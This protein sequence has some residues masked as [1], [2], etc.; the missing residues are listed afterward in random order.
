MTVRVAAAAAASGQR[1]PRAGPAAAAAAAALRLSHIGPHR[2]RISTVPVRRRLARTAATG[3]RS[4]SRSRYDS[5]LKLPGAG[6]PPP[7]RPGR[8]GLLA[9]RDRAPSRGPGRAVHPSPAGPGGARR[10]GRRAAAAVAA[11]PVTTR[12]H[13]HGD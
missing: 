11:E 4:R 3:R 6:R 10:P 7:G 1:P 9:G 13:G 8:P 12:S 5:D 2:A